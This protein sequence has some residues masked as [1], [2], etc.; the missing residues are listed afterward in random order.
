MKLM[1]I[2]VECYSGYKSDE[3]PRRFT[4]NHIDFEIIEIIDRWHEAYQNP[5]SGEITYFKIKTNLAGS[6][7][8]KHDLDGDIWFLVV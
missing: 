4:W 6:Y 2:Q 3:Y 1:P 7:M 5:E 8:L